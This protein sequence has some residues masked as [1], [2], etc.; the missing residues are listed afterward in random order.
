[1]EEAIRRLESSTVRGLEQDEAVRR[2]KL[3]GENKVDLKHEQY[4]FE[5]YRSLAYRRNTMEWI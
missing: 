1:M 2:L 3:Y 5:E 4:N